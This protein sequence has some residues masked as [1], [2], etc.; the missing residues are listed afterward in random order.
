MRLRL[1]VPIGVDQPTGGNVYDL[2]MADALR[3]AGDEVA[4]VECAPGDLA[5]VL[6]ESWSGQVLVD[7]LLACPQPGA[8]GGTRPAVLVHMPLAWRPGISSDEAAELDLLE[9]EALAVS[10]SIVTTSDWCAAHLVERHRVDGIAVVP[11]GVDRAEVVQGSD[12]PLIVHVAAVAAHKNQLGL[13]A[14]L[15]RVADLPWRARLAG[16][17]DVDPAY[18]DT[19][20]RALAAAGLAGRVTMP[21]TV[22]RADAWAGADLAVLPSLAEAYGMVVTEA[23]ARG[24]PAIVTDGGPSEALGVDPDGRRPGVVVPRG[25]SASLAAELR[26]WLTEPDHRAELRERALATRPILDDWDAAATRL[27]AALT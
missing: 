7:G 1:V 17:L 3:R 8:L 27:R 23:L 20:G 26:R 14:A 11:P 25:D 6:H 13:V 12:P 19:V 24:I 2:A 9:A 22:D 5:A 10:S 16:S 15:V 21:G 4:V 18:A